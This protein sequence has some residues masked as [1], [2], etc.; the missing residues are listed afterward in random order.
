MTLEEFISEQQK[1]L[2][3]FEQYW[4]KANVEASKDFPLDMNGGDW[5]EQLICFMQNRDDLVE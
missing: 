4:R 5:D 2:K 3:E 1:L